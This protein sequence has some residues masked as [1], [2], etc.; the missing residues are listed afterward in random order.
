MNKTILSLALLGTFT[1]A[2]KAAFISFATGGARGHQFLLEGGVTRVVTT[3]NNPIARVRVGYVTTPGEISTFIEFATT[4]INNPLTTQTIGGFVNT[5]T[6]NNADVA[7]IRSRQVV[8]WVYGQGGQQGAFTS[9]AWTVPV[10][11]APDV[12]ASFD[13]TL[14]VASGQPIAVTTLGIP[15]FRPA[16]YLAPVT[17]LVGATSNASGASYVL[18]APVPEPTTSITALL[19]VAGLVARRRR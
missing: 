6:G 1:L 19:A 15:D 3:A 16:N 17:I 10:G 8:L 4:T 5:A 14:G 18:G 12:D 2:S 7:G 11:L 9:A 13:V